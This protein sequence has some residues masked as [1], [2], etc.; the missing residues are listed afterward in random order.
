MSTLTKISVGVVA[1]GAILGAL[2]FFGLTPFVKN[3]INNI[4]GNVITGGTTANTSKVAETTMNLTS[5]A[6]T[7]TSILNTDAQD[8]IVINLE[9]FCSAVGTSQTAYTGTGLA[10]LT[11]TAATTSTANPATITNTNSFGFTIATTSLE[12]YISTSTNPANG[13]DGRRWAAGSYMSFAA[14]AT[15]TAQC[16]V[17]V[18]YL[19]GLGV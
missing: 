3:V 7:S 5:G 4:A 13:A 10:A 12:T 14:N 1:V 18:K 16:I 19:Q 17:D 9:T 11:M 6:A 8:R 2:A 15:N